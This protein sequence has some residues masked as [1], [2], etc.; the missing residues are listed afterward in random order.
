MHLS[1]GIL[2]LYFHGDNSV[3]TQIKLTFLYT[4]AA[5][6]FPVFRDCYCLLSCVPEPTSP[7]SLKEIKVLV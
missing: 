2:L 1:I 4:I 7:Y 3:I 6:T 5:Y